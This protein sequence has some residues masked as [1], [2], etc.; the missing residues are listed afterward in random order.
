MY[1]LLEA[2]TDDVNQKAFNSLSIGAA[3]ASHQWPLGRGMLRLVQLTS[4]QM[5]VSLPPETEALFSDFETR[6]WRHQDRGALKSQ[7]PHFAHSMKHGEGQEIELDAFLRRFDGLEIT[8]ELELESES[9]SK[10][11]SEWEEST[12]RGVEESSE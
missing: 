2:L 12:D 7:Y 4:K 11:K 10:S 5:E 3:A 6:L 9:E 1:T 8:P